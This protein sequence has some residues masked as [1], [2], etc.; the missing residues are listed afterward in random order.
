MIKINIFLGGVSKQNV[1]FSKEMFPKK[2]THAPNV[3]NTPWSVSWNLF[4]ESNLDYS[5][6]SIP[7]FPSQT[8]LKLHNIPAT[9]M[10]VRRITTNLHSLKA[11]DPD[12]VEVRTWSYIYILANLFNMHLRASYFSN[13]WSFICGACVTEDIYGLKLL[14]C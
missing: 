11:L 10:M 9:P 4:R 2:C 1:L 5:I 7:A 14:H 13:C 6:I 8:I 3:Q 12:G